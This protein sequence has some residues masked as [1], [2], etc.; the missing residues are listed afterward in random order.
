MNKFLL[1]IAAVVTAI[2]F[3]IV[4]FTLRGALK[5]SPLAQIGLPGTASD[6][7]FLT[8]PVNSF[9]GKVTKVE[10]DVIVLTQKMMLPVSFNPPPIIA[11]GNA[12]TPAPLPTPV[13]KD[14]TFRIRIG[15]QTQISRPPAFVPYLLISVTPPVPARLS[16]GD[17]KPG[18][19]VSVSTS[20]DLRTL[21][22]NEFEASL[23]NLPPIINTLSGKI[24]AAGDNAITL[25]AIP[26]RPNDM[27]APAEPAKEVDYRVRVTKDTEISRYQPVPMGQTDPDPNSTPKAPTV[28]KLSLADLA[29]D[30]QVI[31]YTDTDILGSN[32]FTALRIEPAYVPPAPTSV[33]LPTLS[34]IP[35]AA[36]GEGTLNTPTP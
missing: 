27:S 15:S 21:S 29:A 32:Q 7:L 6:I 26:P 20:T 18:Q 23:I 16:I 22:G 4:G 8:S 34:S 1:P 12:A 35:P 11:T 14:I 13:S 3:T 33:P 9:S 10:K 31:I 30:M 17:I 2:V 5:F 19:M 28:E 36:S 24:T 25:R